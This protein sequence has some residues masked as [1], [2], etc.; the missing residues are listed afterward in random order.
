MASDHDVHMKKR[1]LATV[2]WFFA[3]WY[4]GAVIA[5]FVGVSPML[6]PILG[7][8]AAALIAVDPRGVIWAT[9]RPTAAPAA[10][11]SQPEPI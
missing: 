2:L 3:G 5:Y 11:G 7:A 8:A 9:Q 6:G 10:T 4:A 1:L